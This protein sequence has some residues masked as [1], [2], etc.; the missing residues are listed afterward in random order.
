VLLKI[1][2]LGG[3]E[4]YLADD[5]YELTNDWEGLIQTVSG[6]DLHLPVDGKAR[7]RGNAQVTLVNG[8]LM[9]QTHGERISDYF[10]DIY[11][12]GATGQLY[13]H[14]LGV[15]ETET[16][17]LS[18]FKGKVSRPVL[19]DKGQ[20]V[21]LTITPGDED[22]GVLPPYRVNQT[23]YPN[24][25]GGN[26][27]KPMPIIWG[28]LKNEGATGGGLDLEDWGGAFPI[29][30][31]LHRTNHRALIAGHPIEAL[32]GY[33]THP[34]WTDET[35][36]V[37]L[38]NQNPGDS[39]VDWRTVS[40]AM[41]DGACNPDAGD[42]C[43][44]KGLESQGDLT[45][46]ISSGT[47]LECPKLLLEQSLRMFLAY[48]AG[49]FLT[50]D[51]L[52]ASDEKAA[53]VIVRDTTVGK[54][55]NRCNKQFKLMFFRGPTGKINCK[56][57]QTLYTSG[58]EIDLKDEVEF[59]KIGITKDNYNSVTMKFWK[60]LIGDA[61]DN[62]YWY[63]DFDI[64]D[65][66]YLESFIRFA[67]HPTRETVSTLFPAGNTSFYHTST[68]T[69]SFFK[70]GDLILMGQEV[71]EV[72]TQHTTTR[73]EVQRRGGLGTDDVDHAIGEDIFFLRTQSNCGTGINDG[74]GNYGSSYQHKIHVWEAVG[75]YATVTTTYNCSSFSDPIRW[76]ER[77]ATDLTNNSTLKGNYSGTWDGDTNRFKL[78][79]T[80]AQDFQ[81][82]PSITDAIPDYLCN[83]LMGFTSDTSLGEEHWSDSP[84][85][86]REA[87]A[88][89]A[90]VRYGVN[91]PLVIEGDFL[92]FD[93]FQITDHPWHVVR[94]RNRRFDATIIPRI[95]VDF[96][97]GPRLYL[98]GLN[99]IV[100]FSDSFDSV[101]KP[102]GK[103]WDGK[104]WRIIKT[105]KPSITRF[106]YRVREVL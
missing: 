56:E 60:N 55:I 101:M 18:L 90:Y 83:P 50:T 80:N 26:D 105:W 36:N 30:I 43:D 24:A 7:P 1:T 4:I 71:M 21:R 38:S 76:A 72:K 28:E 41:P 74:H 62:K 14:M 91:K 99:G 58:T 45:S 10:N 13:F 40:V 92:R 65:D 19:T 25:K 70:N 66:F 77:I 89:W 9:R 33:W 44:V 63:G 52:S 16:L 31:Q 103:S 67:K 37:Q 75:Q 20:K 78:W 59:K 73:T 51:F 8:R 49:D 104:T 15:S 27:G 11:F 86:W 61:P 100:Q 22:S 87:Q 94:G 95:E 42:R 81:I 12:F 97:C 32:T 48:T 39:S 47:F 53:G 64:G 3:D 17:T 98:L 85:W 34:S 57:W 46:G 68:P 84:T 82:K 93:S 88:A 29:N 54:L 23:E 5:Y 79:T 35:G 2:T 102:F 69:A 6:M 96:E 106:G